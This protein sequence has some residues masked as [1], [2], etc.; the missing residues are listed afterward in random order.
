LKTGQFILFI[1]IV[2]TIY[3]LVNF[4]IFI[5]GLQA[6]PAAG[7]YRLWF[8]IGYWLTASTFIL[9]RL[10]GHNYPCGFSGVFT[11][12]GSFWLAFMLYFFILIVIFDLTRLSNH[13]FHFLP[14]SLYIDYERTKLVLLYLSCIMVSLIIVI[15]FI[16]ARIPRIREIDIPISKAIAGSKRVRVVLVSDIHMGTLVAQ[17][18][19]NRLVKTI[20]ELDPDIVLFAGD[21]VDEDLAPVIKN[22]LG[23]ALSEIRSRLGVYTITGNHEYIGGVEP[24][25]KYLSE[26][27]LKILRD[28]IVLIDGRFYLAGRDDRDK[29][30]FS[31]RKRKELNQI[32]EG[33]D[34]SYPVI[35][36]DHQPF[37]LNKVAEEGIDLQLSGHTHHGQI[38]PFNLITNAMYE[39]SWGYRKI[40]NTHFYVSSGYGTWGPPIRLGNRPEIVILN[41]TFN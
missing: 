16:N 3:L 31:G 5:R 2:L 29:F 10:V 36:L 20:N 18:K 26:H 35:L 38:W 40:G 22:N 14:K 39:V 13:Y 41:L 25:L 9:A 12:V 19:T 24:A 37:N 30:R 6:I 11:W 15:G 7:Q 32:L 1:A 4:Y 27:G 33:I 28:T 23:M 8:S 17:R 34:R 21:V